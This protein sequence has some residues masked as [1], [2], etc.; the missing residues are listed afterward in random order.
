MIALS[1][2]LGRPV[3]RRSLRSCEIVIRMGQ[4]LIN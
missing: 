1:V 2:G 4:G 3:R